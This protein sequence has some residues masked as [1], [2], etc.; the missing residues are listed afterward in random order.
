MNQNRFN[1][2]II[3]DAIPA[4]EFNTARRLKEELD[5]IA[6]YTIQ[7]LR[8]LY[9]RIETMMDLERCLRD[10]EQ[11]L[12]DSGLQPLLHLEGHGLTDESGFVL[13][14]GEHCSWSKLKCFASV[15][16][17]LSSHLS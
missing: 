10:A 16:N 14:R 13:A 2:I 9:F 11:K 4:G 3:L 5:D 6:A 7:G 12:H 1:A 17:G 15:G 8:V